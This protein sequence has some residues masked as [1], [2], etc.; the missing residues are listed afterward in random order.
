MEPQRREIVEG[1]LDARGQY[2]ERT[3]T[4]PGTFIPQLFPEWEI[5]VDNARLTSASVVRGW[6]TLPA[7]IS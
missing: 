1:V 5:D 4:A 6:E 7:F 3:V 2:R